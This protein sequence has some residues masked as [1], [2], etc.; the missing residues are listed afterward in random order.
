ML[1]TSVLF[2]FISGCYLKSWWWDPQWNNPH[3]SDVL[4]IHDEV[5]LY[6]GV[7][8]GTY[9]EVVYTKVLENHDGVGHI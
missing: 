5:T 8:L 7:L 9:K 1:R 4:K 3:K 6:K 2:V